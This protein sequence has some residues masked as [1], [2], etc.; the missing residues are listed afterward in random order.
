MV[1]LTV[2]VPIVVLPDFVTHVIVQVPDVEFV[3]LFDT[4][5]TVHVTLS[6]AL[7]LIVPV[8]A[9]ILYVIVC[10]KELEALSVYIVTD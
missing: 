5:G 1:K 7:E 8:V 10:V 6:P 3:I 4:S 2:F 9:P